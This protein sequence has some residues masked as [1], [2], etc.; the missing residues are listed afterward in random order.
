MSSRGKGYLLIA[1]LLGDPTLKHVDIAEIAGCSTKKVQRVAKKLREETAD[2]DEIEAYKEY[3]RRQMPTEDR[4]KRLVELATQDRQLK[5]ALDAIVRMDSMQGLLTE[6]EKLQFRQE[7][8]KE[9]GPLFYF[10][11]GSQPIINM[12]IGEEQESTTQDEAG[13]AIEAAVIK[14]EESR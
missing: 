2:L 13:E 11:P 6:R 1:N 12:K 14:E 5:V 7:P 8:E 4:A 9:T 10:P 3:I